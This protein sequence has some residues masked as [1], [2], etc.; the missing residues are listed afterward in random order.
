MKMRKQSFALIVGTGLAL[1]ACGDMI[2][3]ESEM[4]PITR[5]VSGQT[6]IQGEN[7]INTN[8]DGTMT[9]TTAGGDEIRGAWAVRNGQWCRT[10]TLPARLAGTACQDV[11]LGD[12]EITFTAADGGSATYQVQ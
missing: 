6:L 11:E 10:L 5:A 2:A 7:V 1:T 4:D 8:A 12:G 3:S 9:G